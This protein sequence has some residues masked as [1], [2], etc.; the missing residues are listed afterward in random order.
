MEDVRVRLC[1]G[2]EDGHEV[3]VSADPSGKPIPRITMPLKS[4]HVR[5]VVVY[6]RHRARRD[7]SWEFN[8]VGVEA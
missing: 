5:A 7:G 6:E 4:P 2:P 3:S 1:G 8:Y